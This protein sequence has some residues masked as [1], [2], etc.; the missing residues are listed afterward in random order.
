[1]EYPQGSGRTN[2]KIVTREFKGLN[3]MAVGAEGCF[4][5]CENISSEYPCIHTASGYETADTQY[6]NIQAMI[7]PNS[8]SGFCG[9]ANGVLYWNGSAVSAAACANFTIK[10][11]TEISIYMLNKYLYIYERRTDGNVVLYEYDTIN[12][13]SKKNNT[14]HVCF[15]LNNE[16]VYI[17]VGA[18]TIENELEVYTLTEDEKVII[19]GP[20]EDVE[21]FMRIGIKDYEAS[22]TEPL[23]AKKGSEISKSTTNNVT[24]YTWNITFYNKK[25]AQTLPL[26][27]TSTRQNVGGIYI[28]NK[29]MPKTTPLEIYKNRVWGGMLDGSSIIGTALGSGYDFFSFKNTA[30]DSVELNVLTDGAFVGVK[31][32]ADALI[33]FKENSIT[34]V[35]GD[36]AYDFSLGKTITGVG[37]IDIRSVCT[38]DGVLYFC[39]GDG[40]YAYTGGQPEFISSNIKCKYKRCIAFSQNG[41]YYAEGTKADGSKEILTYD[42]RTGLWFREVSQGITYICSS[43]G[44][45]YI[46]TAG[47]MK[48]HR[49]EYDYKDNSPE[50]YFESMDLYEGIYEKKGISE[51]FVRAKLEEG[52]R[53]SVSTVTD[54]G[55]AV[56]HKSF[57]GNGYITT[58]RVPVKFEKQES[59][60]YRISGSGAAL[61]YDIERKV[62]AGG[63]NIGE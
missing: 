2:G 45:I 18:I 33:C 56:E 40:F 50:W 13:K 43:G 20:E 48:K 27:N 7:K 35:Y 32:F 14:Y 61:I 5:D 60:R 9:V 41:K 24:Y 36:T 16:A 3:H 8:I 4:S 30:A 52:T 1:M 22:D 44:D 54:S 59:Y 29:M 55:E 51:I 19:Y 23:Y 63:R 34:V 12:R 6:T 53:M 28:Y 39:S 49:R 10:S 11:N 58:Y 46:A 25:D 42:T 57:Y 17:R 62:P 47:G 26:C 31:A 38:V 37:C 15:Q 21:R